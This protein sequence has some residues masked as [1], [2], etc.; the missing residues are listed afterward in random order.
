MA[1]NQKGFW[2]NTRN[3]LLTL[4]NANAQIILDLKEDLEEI[5]TEINHQLKAAHQSDLKSLKN[6]RKVLLNDINKLRENNR[7]EISL[8]V[9]ETARNHGVTSPQLEL[10]RAKALAA[11]NQ[12]EKAIQI[13]NEQASSNKLK[14]KQ[15]ANAEI[16]AYEKSHLSASE[17]LRSIRAA[18]RSEMIES[19]YI[20]EIAPHQASELERQIL[21]E[22]I[23][24]RKNNNEKLSLELLEICIQHGV[25]SYLID[26]NKARALFKIGLK[27]EAIH[28]WQSLLSNNDGEK[29]KSAQKILFQLSQNLLAA[30]KKTIAEN[31]QDV[32][33][34]P[35]QAPQ[36]LS[37]L[38][39]LILREAI[40]L[41]KANQEELSLQILELTTSAGFET[42]AINENRARALINLKRNTEAVKLLQELLSSKKEE[43]QESANR[44]LKSLGQKLL[45]QTRDLLNKNCWKIRHLP[46][47]SPEHLAKLEPLILKEAIALRKEKKERLSLAI[48]NLSIELGL[49]TEKIDDNRARALI[50]DEQYFEAVTIWN[51]LKDSK[52]TQ[53]QQSA[54][55]MLER[56]SEKGFQQ[57]ILQEVNNILANDNDK[58]QAINLLTDAILKNP[59]D[60]KLH[61]KL[62]EVATKDG[63]KT[64][65]SDQEFEELNSHAQA[66][67]GFEAFVTSL[68]QRHMPALKAADDKQDPKQ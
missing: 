30:I 29:E 2:K 58:T 23:E 42:D 7:P 43:T 34:L 26:D 68:E 61:E 15:Q 44:I 9:I 60:H 18:L 66:L 10:G 59:N 21:N 40:A 32:Q 17:L 1:K 63:D 53:I 8:K 36:D 65:Q 25:R 67:A 24:L 49:K 41:R 16:K 45:K 50:N 6:L 4:G 51:S 22:S 35:E 19:K 48:L 38:G 46:E 52:N 28:I 13:W 55:S 5:E 11:L 37:K 31:G 39:F 62:G 64:N 33:H 3:F 54:T 57:K 12:H 47:E 56:F 27:R 14:V 20:P